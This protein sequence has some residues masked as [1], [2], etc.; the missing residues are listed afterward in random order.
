RQAVEAARRTADARRHDVVLWPRLEELALRQEELA[1]K[2]AR[3]QARRD[4]VADEVASGDRSRCPAPGASGED[5][6]RAAH[7]ERAPA[8]GSA[9]YR[10]LAEARRVHEEALARLD[11]RLSEVRA[12]GDKVRGELARLASSLDEVRSQAEARRRHRWWTAAWW[13]AG[14]QGNVLARI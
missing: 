7:A 3:L 10:E 11:A 4:G 13:K 14:R 9:F 6:F 2:I 5:T 12:E 1:A 8:A